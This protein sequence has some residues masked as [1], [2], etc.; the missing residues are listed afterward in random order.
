VN[1]D[2]IA[3]AIGICACHGISLGILDA[4][5]E[6]YSVTKNLRFGFGAYDTTIVCNLAKRGLTG[7]VS[8]IEGPRGFNKI[9]YQ[10]RMDLDLNQ[11]FGS[12]FNR[13]SQ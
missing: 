4:H 5:R 3:N 6:E 2:Q 1:E 12:F 7:P 13:S 11:L 10:N 9:G 8:I